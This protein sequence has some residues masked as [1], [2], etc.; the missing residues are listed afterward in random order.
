M[1]AA[2]NFRAHN[3]WSNKHVLFVKIKK[4]MK[5]LETEE[6]VTEEQQ[7]VL[8]ELLWYN[9]YEWTFMDKRHTNTDGNNPSVCTDGLIIVIKKP[10]L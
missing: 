5:K 3:K 2:V 6:A 1:D 4:A 10:F 8:T 7:I 9:N